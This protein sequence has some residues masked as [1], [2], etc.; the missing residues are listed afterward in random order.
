MGDWNVIESIATYLAWIVIGIIA[1][2]MYRKHAVK[3][4]IW[5]VIIVILIGL[6]S[7]SF[8]WNVFNT[9]VQIS[10]LPLGVW[11]LYFFL[12]KKKDRWKKYRP[13]AWL[14]FFANFI[15]L[16]STFIAIPVNHLIYPENEL[17]TLISSVENASLINIH[18]SAKESFLI[19][20][21]LLKEI[22]SLKQKEF[23]SDEWYNETY[24]TE[25][26]KRKERFPYMLMNASPKWGSGLS[27]T[28]Y[29]E[30]DGKGVLVLT[31]NKQLYF[32]SEHSLLE[33]GK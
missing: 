30:S 27:T 18:P 6:F 17:S 2:H 3:P 26:N 21:N 11:F 28:V 13:F 9:M 15:I 29:L 20:E 14:G 10:V 7:F 33:E 19:D 5:K 8:K 23:F 1:F 25:S 22:H 24:S 12:N 31:P 16:L 4:K 32:H